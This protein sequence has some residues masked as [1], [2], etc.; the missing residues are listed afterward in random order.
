[1]SIKKREVTYQCDFCGSE[2]EKT[3]DVEVRY[4]NGYMGQNPSNLHVQVRGE[5]SYGPADPDICLDCKI[6]AIEKALN[7]YKGIKATEEEQ[8]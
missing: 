8:R 7:T 2:M 5:I 3:T 1:V 4:S 6:I